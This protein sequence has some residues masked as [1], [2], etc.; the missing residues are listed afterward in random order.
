M[1]RP[2]FVMGPA[3][4]AQQF[5]KGEI[6][7]FTAATFPYTFETVANWSYAGI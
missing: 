6:N 2:G 5:G 1:A 3:A 4:D 7:D